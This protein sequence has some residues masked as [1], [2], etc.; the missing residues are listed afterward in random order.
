M[1]DTA[2]EH[3][4]VNRL[5]A[6][7]DPETNVDVIR[8]QLVQSLRVDTAGHVS[9]TFR[10]SSFICPI[11]VTLAVN[12]KRAVATVTGVTSQSIEIDGYAMADELQ[13]L[14]N[15]EV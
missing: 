15:Q 12:I 14:I 4:V 2:L 3:A 10:P 9:Y 6:V 5:R 13:Q 8:M 1:T 7:I 11:A